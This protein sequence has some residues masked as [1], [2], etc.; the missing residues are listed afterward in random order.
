[1]KKLVSAT[2]KSTQQVNPVILD[3]V[4]MGNGIGGTRVSGKTREELERSFDQAMNLLS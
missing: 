3:L 4:Q 1:M 2:N